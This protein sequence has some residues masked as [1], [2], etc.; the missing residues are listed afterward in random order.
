MPL[1][2]ESEAPQIINLSSAAQA[3]VNPAILLG[4]AKGSDSNTY[5]QSK[6]AL[7][8]WSFDLAKQ[9]PNIAVLALNPG[10]LLN[11]RMVQ[12]AYGQYWSP[13][14]KGANI[15]YDLAV[16]QQFQGLT[17][18]YYDHDNGGWGHAHADAD[19]EQK[20]KALLS[21]TEEIIAK[22]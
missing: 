18:K 20:I 8:M 21:L 13:A 14:D 7:T 17:G 11:T 16:G 1:L 9:H 10:S 6:L 12:E 5:A 3:P 19:E 4:T 22:F 15:I 2:Q